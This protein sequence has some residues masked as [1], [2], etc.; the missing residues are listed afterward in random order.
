MTEYLD[1]IVETWPSW[2]LLVSLAV[3]ILV[4]AKGADVLVED[5]VAI[6]LQRG[7]PSVV[8]GATVVSLGTTTPEAVVSVLAAVQG[9]SEL[10]LGNAVGSIICDTGL[11]LGI[12]CLI[13][14][15][16]FDRSM[17]NRQGSVQL[18]SG[19]LLVVACVPWGQP[20]GVTTEGGVLPQF[21]GWL[22]LALLAVYLRWSIQLA[23]DA[24]LDTHLKDHN[25]PSAHLRTAVSIVVAIMVVVVSSSLLI[26]AATEMAVRFNVPSSVIAAT[27]VAFGTS[28]PELVIVV[29]AALKGQGGLAIGNII[30]ADILNVLFVAGAAAA[31][32]PSGLVADPSF[33]L[34]QFPAMLFILALFRL[35][36]LTS[37][38][39]TLRRPLGAVLLGAYL[40]VT[41]TS[42]LSS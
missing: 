28:L 10:A 40:F 6:S 7:V 31:V 39:S 19:L 24:P 29:T 27:L 15:L 13:S 37:R 22:F 5:A 11:I 25:P 38:T 26:S 12:A 16:P 41:V 30:G 35:G 1:A 17:V 36:T 9:R 21:V 42:Y 34:L 14:P 18:A 3:G 20:L 8:V 32:T 23:R 2:A 33:F 4:L